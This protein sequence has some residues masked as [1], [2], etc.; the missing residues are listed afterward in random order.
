MPLTRGADGNL[1]VRAQG[2][3]QAN[4]DVVI[5]N[6]SNAQASTNETTDSKGNRRIEVT[7]GDMTAGEM[8]RSGSATQKS[9]R[10]TYGIQPQLIRR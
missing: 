1:G 3:S 7:I 2:N 4:V 6:Y 9:L 8:G 5:N 10:N